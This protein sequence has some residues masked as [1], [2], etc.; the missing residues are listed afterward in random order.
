MRETGYEVETAS[1]GIEALAKV[2]LGR[3]LYYDPRMSK[4]Q[5]ISCN[6]CHLLDKFGVDG[7]PTSKG[8]N[9]QFGARNSP[10]VYNAAGQF[11]AAVPKTGTRVSGFNINAH[12]DLDGYREYLRTINT[13][14]IEANARVP[15]G[16]E[17]DGMQ[18]LKDYLLKSREDDIAENVLRRLLSYGLGRELTYHD[19]YA[20]E[21][22][23]ADCKDSD[24][25]LRDMIVSVCL[26]DSFRKLPT[27]TE[28]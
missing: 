10:T 11:Q 6:T 14:E 13:I 8:H 18:E 15:H 23:L 17:V 19:R 12:G 26:S 1:D 22:L 5:E 24:Y 4:N 28:K 9:D 25:A 27:T 20:V 3:K 16:P 2:N 7:L 21:A